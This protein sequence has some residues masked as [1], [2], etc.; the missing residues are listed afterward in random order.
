M[1]AAL[2]III[3]TL[4][5]EH[6]LPGCLQTLIPGLEAGVIREL[7]ITDGGSDDATVHIAEEAGA[8]IV[9]GPA[10][11]G[12]QLQRGAERAQGEW[13]L[14]L[15][16]DTRLSA[17]WVA[18]VQGHFGRADAGYFQ[19]RF[20]AP[21]LRPRLVAGWANLRARILGLPYGDQGLL[22]PR[23]LYIACGGYDDIP[24]MEDVALAQRLR[25]QL[26][27]LPATALTR[28]D[29]Y[30]SEGWIRRGAEN[31]WLLLRYLLGADPK[32]LAERYQPRNKRG[33]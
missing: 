26:H 14:F 21:G 7:I 8:D 24:L 25:G 3:P 20:D 2:S 18:A 29:R 16:A 17:D 33:H 1:R 15:H 13:L 10:S 23:N 4:N 27:P 6:S 32:K 9:A 11:R 31:L 5:A 30:Q 22:I 19:L 12:G 28:A